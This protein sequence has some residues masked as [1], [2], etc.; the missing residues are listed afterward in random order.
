M[1]F[2]LI[3]RSLWVSFFRTSFFMKNGTEVV[4][5]REMISHYKPSK[6]SRTC[7]EFKFDNH[8]RSRTVEIEEIMDMLKDKAVPFLH[9]KE[10]I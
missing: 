3:V 5:P 2:N 7:G 9:L 8:S 6:K 4:F 1:V 10:V